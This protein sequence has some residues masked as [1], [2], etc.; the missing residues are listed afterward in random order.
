MQRKILLKRIKQKSFFPMTYYYQPALGLRGGLAR[1][2]YVKS[3]RKTCAPAVDINRLM[4][5]EENVLLPTIAATLSFS[6]SSI[7]SSPSLLLTG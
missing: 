7:T 4:M 3:I 6:D 2:P 5:S 1:S